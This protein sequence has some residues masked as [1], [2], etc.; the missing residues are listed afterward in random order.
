MD[1]VRI[2]R[3]R[4]ARRT[5]GPLHPV[6]RAYATN[7]EAMFAM[8]GGDVARGEELTTAAMNEAP[9]QDMMLAFY[10][11]QL[12]WVWWQRD[13][14]PPLEGAIRAMGDTAPSYGMVRAT[15]ALVCA[16]RGGFDDAR[17]ELC[18]LTAGDAPVLT[19][20]ET[21]GVAM[22]MA[23]AAA[24]LTG[25]HDEAITVY[26]HLEPY[27]GTAIVVRAPA[28]AYFGP[29]DYYLGL[30]GVALG[31]PAL[32]ASHFEAAL[33]LGERMGAVLHVAAA[34]AELAR[35]LAD[36]GGAHPVRAGELARAAIDRA[37][38]QGLTRI[39]RRAQEVLDGT[40]G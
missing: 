40:A 1:L 7:L 26:R 14:F 39:V 19:F 37:A 15:L 38:P 20:D 3:E 25:A 32:A 16:E 6:G 24:E 5:S 29:A 2:E 13:Q 33:A 28:D 10:A 18:E 12:L 36:A 34:Q 23:S 30:L 21:D 31:D 35:V 22:A 27:A 4:F 9:G 11:I 8:L 17:G